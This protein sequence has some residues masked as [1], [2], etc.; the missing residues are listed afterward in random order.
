MKRGR[1]EISPGFLLLWA[2]FF[3]LDK[4]AIAPWAL[5]ACAIHELAHVAALYAAGGRVGA[6][7]LTAAGAELT[8]E[9]GKGLSYGGELLS[10]LAGPGANLFLAVVSARGGEEWYPFAGL[11]LCL[12]VFNLLP[13]PGLDGG[14]AVRLLLCMLTGEKRNI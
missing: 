8:G 5:A 14:R 9:R 12:G 1:V 7:R 2:L 4:E 13:M 11:N 10:V 6:F 3:F